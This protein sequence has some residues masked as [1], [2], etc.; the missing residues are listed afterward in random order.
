MP[1][2]IKPNT[3]GQD[4]ANDERKDMLISYHEN[5]FHLIPCG[6]TTDIIPEYFKTRHPF[7]DDMVLQKR[8]SKTP[9]VKWAD[10]IT[11]QPTLNEIKQ[12]Y[13]QFPECNWAAITGVT[14]VVLDADTQEACDFCE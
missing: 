10:Y 8:W 14:F 3:V 11:R 9:R 4:I 6:S 1:I 5:F 7:E 13:L 12:W 2:E